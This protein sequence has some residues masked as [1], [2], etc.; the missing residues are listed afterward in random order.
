MCKIISLTFGD[1]TRDNSIC[2]WRNWKIP[3]V[4]SSNLCEIFPHYN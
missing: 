2:C 4:V 1:H 3:D